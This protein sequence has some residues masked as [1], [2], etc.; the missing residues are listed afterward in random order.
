MASEI[1][2]LF[3]G[4]SFR[5]VLDSATDAMVI[6]DERGRVL[7]AN[8]AMGRLFG[9]QQGELLGLA[10]EHL[11]PERFRRAHQDHRG[12]YADQ[13]RSRAMGAGLT[14]L[15]MR[16][17][18]QEFPVDI[19]LS[20]LKTGNR[21][22]TLATIHDI[23]R[24][25]QAE[26]R[27]AE[28]TARLLASETRLRAVLN[29]AI[30]GI[31]VL[32]ERG[33]IDSFNPAAERMFGYREAEIKGAPISMVMSSPDREKHEAALAKYIKTGEG[34][35]IGQINEIIG[36]RRSGLSFPMEFGLAEMW[37]GQNRWFAASVRDVSERHDA[38]QRKLALLRE[39][40]SK[41]AEL[42]RFVYTVSH[43][44][45]SPLITIQGFAGMLEKSAAKEDFARMPGDIS[46]IRAAADKMQMLLNDLLELSRIG[47][48][49]N[50]PAEVSLA[51]LVREAIDLVAGYDASRGVE[52]AISQHLPTVVGDRQRLLEVFLNLI[53]NA[54][55]FMGDQSAPRIE[56]GVKDTEGE[57]ICYVRDNGIGIDPRY[58][59][60]IFGLFERLDQH[61]E[62]TGIG[63]A[64]AKRIVEVHSGR[65][66]V[67]SEGPGHG[68]V[69]CFSLP[70]SSQSGA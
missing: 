14:L 3:E 5:S 57:T 37:L 70:S 64:I 18:G 61:K 32:D 56:I 41:N 69:F 50:P 68:S 35:I 19:S 51:D 21:Q 29:T 8:H 63:L 6:T 40:E 15:A 45:K 1:E 54:V 10:I 55:K 13:P 24:R 47:R 23:S 7:F 31:V 4:Q 11:I 65:I 26:E 16:K 43:D 44:L 42:E 58:H 60:K 30:D 62:G 20:P 9:Y 67:E 59:Q 52:I 28:Q 33:F 48:V 34:E 22:L 38:Q 53:D 49:A 36:L 46:R 27:L 17:D 12:Q 25:R 66:W 39:L 2:G